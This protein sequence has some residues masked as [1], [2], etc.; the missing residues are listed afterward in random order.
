MMTKEEYELYKKYDEKFKQSCGKVCEALAHYENDYYNADIDSC[1]LSD[2]SVYVTC[3]GYNRGYW[4][5][6]HRFSDELLTMTEDELTAE[7]DRMIRKRTEQQ[8]AQKAATEK[9]IEKEE[10][11]MYQRLKEKFENK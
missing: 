3:S 8:L 9:A 5:E 1:Y 2:G 10:F 7:V 6:H 11:T 4:E